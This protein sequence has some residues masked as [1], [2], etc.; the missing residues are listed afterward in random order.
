MS[1]QIMVIIVNEHLENKIS[2]IIKNFEISG[3]VKHKAKG[4]SKGTFWEFFN[5]KREDKT[6][7]FLNTTSSVAK[8]IRSAINDNENNNKKQN[9][10]IMFNLNCGRNM[11]MKNENSM[12]V[13]VVD[14]GYSSV[15]M[16]IARENGATGGTIFDAKGTGANFST[17]LGIDIN[18]EKEIILNVVDSK[19]EKKI[20]REIKKHFQEENVTGISFS[21]PIN[22]FVGINNK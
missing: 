4:T 14:Y 15:V 12:I 6:I 16:K 1:N 9:L 19:I 21:M 17:F 18:S 11:I 5:I 7:Y 20:V 22:N 13:T 10:G 2:D 3:V 8:K